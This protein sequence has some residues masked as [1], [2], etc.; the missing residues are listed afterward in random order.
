MKTRKITYTVRFTDRDMPGF[1]DMLRYD[2]GRVEKWDRIVGERYGHSVGWLVTLTG[3]R[4][5]P[6]RWSSFGIAAKEQD[7]DWV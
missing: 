6:D 5:T 7:R 2:Q 1:L 4:F 3:E